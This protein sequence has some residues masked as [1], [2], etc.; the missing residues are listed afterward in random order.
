MRGER[1]G[2]VEVRMLV[3]LSLLTESKEIRIGS[4]SGSRP[5]FLRRLVVID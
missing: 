4:G 5:I 2:A 1:R 3:C